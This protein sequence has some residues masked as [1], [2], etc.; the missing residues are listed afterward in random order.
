MGYKMLPEETIDLGQEGSTFARVLSG[1][2]TSTTRHE[3]GWRSQGGVPKVGEKI[4]FKNFED[5]V[6][7]VTVTKVSTLPRNLFTSPEHR[8]L[9]DDMTNRRLDRSRV[10]IS[11]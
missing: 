9:L 1:K 5:D 6:V 8:P 3:G 10:R 2:R 7:G 11:C 4:Y